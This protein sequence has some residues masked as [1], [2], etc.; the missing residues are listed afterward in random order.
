MNLRASA[1]GMAGTLA[2]GA[3]AL[4]LTVAMTGCGT[5]GAPLPPSLKLPEPVADLAAVRQGNQVTLSWKMPRRTTDKVTIKQAIAVRVCRRQASEGC[6]TEGAEIVLGP[7][8]DGAFTDSLPAALA[9]GAPRPLSYFVELKNRNGRSAGLSNAATVLAGEAPTPVAGLRAELRKDG[10]ALAWTAPAAEPPASVVRLHRRLLTPAGKP[11]NGLLAPQP[12]PVEQSLL[13]DDT[14]HP[15]RAMDASIRFGQTYEY[16]AQRVARVPAEGQTLELAGPLSEP[17]RVE[18]RDIF[19]PAAPGSLAAVASAEANGP[20]P[21]IDLSWQPDIETSLA[22]YA[23]YRA[24]G[25]G[26]WQRISPAEPLVAPAFRD[27]RVEPG[28]TYRYAVTAIGQN[29]HESARSAE[30][31]EVVPQP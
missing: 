22:G 29:G 25:E 24:E 4:G 30:A 13:V 23:V 20:A 3:L 2:A 8:A 5:P 10:V 26:P 14:A 19:P 12:E 11:G 17:I 1:Q 31:S 7:G 15:G 9:T 27:E 21:V 28:H 18:A 6:E 16:R